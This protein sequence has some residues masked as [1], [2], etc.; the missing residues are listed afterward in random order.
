MSGAQRSRI[1]IELRLHRGE[2][3]VHYVD[4]NR[5]PRCCPPLTRCLSVSLGWMSGYSTIR[6]TSRPASQPK[7]TG[8][9][10]GAGR[11]LPGHGGGGGQV[12]LICSGR[13]EKRK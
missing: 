10:S 5:F 8:A 3:T 11:A 1:P 9:L 7:Q 12:L 6:V 4:G 2:F 13:N